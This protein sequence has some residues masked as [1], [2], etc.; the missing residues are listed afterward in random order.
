MKVAKNHRLNRFP[1]A[2]W[3]HKRTRGT[4]LRS[5][6]TTKSVLAAVL[7]TGLGGRQT[8]GNHSANVTD[9]EQFFSE[10]GM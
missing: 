9:D 1:V 6:I 2:V 10:I 3:K 5:G 4:L 7:R 8:S